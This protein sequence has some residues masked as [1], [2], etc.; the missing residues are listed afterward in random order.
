[1]AAVDRHLI[2]KG[3]MVHLDEMEKIPL[4]RLKKKDQMSFADPF[5]KSL[6]DQNP[7][8]LR[9]CSRASWTSDAGRSSVLRWKRNGQDTESIM[10]GKR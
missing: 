3:W 9:L 5:T 7:F 1:M 10:I 4:I 6:D 2:E 8:K